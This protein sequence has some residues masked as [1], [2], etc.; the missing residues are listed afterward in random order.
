VAWSE[1]Q[2]ELSEFRSPLGDVA[3]GV[4]VVEDGP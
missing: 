2:P 4:G 3:C 1:I